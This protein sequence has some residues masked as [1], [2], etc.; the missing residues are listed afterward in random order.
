M[1]E[2]E[3]NLSE[4]QLVL[5]TSRNLPSAARLDAHE[6]ALHESFLA[7]GA[8][9]EAEAGRVDEAELVSRLRDKLLSPADR[10]QRIVR[11]R[12]GWMVIAASLA[13]SLLMAM[14]W[15][16]RARNVSGDVTV[17]MR[18]APETDLHSK[19]LARTDGQVAGWDD[20]LDDEIARA[21][22]TIEQLASHSPMV[23][24]S[25]SDRSLSDVSERLENLSLELSGESL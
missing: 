15:N 19:Q 14:L 2:H 25:I 7:L 8:A 13:A 11:G 1:N 20:P 4:E 18:P 9:V 6:A 17:A 3:Q 10:P 22:A 23:S 5:V 24:G 16:L 21:A 12:V